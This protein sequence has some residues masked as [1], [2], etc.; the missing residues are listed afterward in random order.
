MIDVRGV[1][2]HL[3]GQRILDGLTFC[4]PS[5]VVT[6]LLG[7]NG[8]GKTTT[9]RVLATLLVPDEGTVVIDGIDLAVDPVEARRRIGLVT[10]EPGLYDRLTVREQLEFAGRAHGMG[11]RQVATRVESLAE[12]VA[13]TPELDRRAGVLSKGNSQ[14]ASLCRALVH[15]PAVLLLDEPTSGLDVVAAAGLEDLLA[16]DDLTAGRTVLLSTHR[17]D[18]AERLA[19]RV[20]GLGGGRVVVDDRVDVLTAQA[21]GSFRDLFVRLLADAVMATAEEHG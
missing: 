12:M 9:M 11:R 1:V 16:G 5:G 13:L 3:G 17:V 18:E 8:A 21:G 7:P 14:K 19:E 15:D 6:G 4:A 20:V 2:K 10:E